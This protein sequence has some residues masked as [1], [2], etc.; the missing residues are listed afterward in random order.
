MSEDLACGN[1][2]ALKSQHIGGR[3]RS[4]VSDACLEYVEPTGG[5]DGSETDARSLIA[6]ATAETLVPVAAGLIRRLIERRVGAPADATGSQAQLE[7]LASDNRQLTAQLQE[8]RGQLESS[9]RNGAMLAE[10][11]VQQSKTIEQL[12]A[13]L[14][15][16]DSDTVANA[17]DSLVSVIREQIVS[18]NQIHDT[19]KTALAPKTDPP[20]L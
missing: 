9:D 6:G 19:L 11:I 3:G 4:V 7:K 10:K 16:G 20:V 1:C 17:I 12:E 5:D 8:T 13:K 15:A 18:T 14:A 2:G